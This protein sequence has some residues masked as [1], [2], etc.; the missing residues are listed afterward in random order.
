MIFPLTFFWGKPEGHEAKRGPRKRVIV[1]TQRAYCK[2]G[3]FK[4]PVN[5]VIQMDFKHHVIKNVLQNVL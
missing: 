4:E 3:V 5:P 1:A 2:D